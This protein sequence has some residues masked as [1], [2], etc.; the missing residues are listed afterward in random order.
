[1]C[2]LSWALALLVAGCFTPDLGEGQV[3]CGVDDACPP[4]YV[5]RADGRC[6]HDA[7]DGGASGATDLAGS[8]ADL[9]NGG[10]ARCARACPPT[11]S[12]AAGV[13]TPPSG[14][15]MCQRAQDC[16]NG[17]VCDEYNVGGMLHGFCTPPIAGAPGG[18]A[19]DCSAP[20]DDASCQTGLCAVDAK[21]SGRRACLVPC[22]GDGDCVSGKCQAS[23]GEPATIDGAPAMSV[24][25][26]TR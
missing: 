4:S 5:C 16:H 20:G 13:C 21:D 23:V 7:G 8:V 3:L 19:D 6:Y 1:M 10:A 26:C 25:F 2:R 24:K 17:Q 14:A 18:A 9:G 12:C 22:K 15:T 11:S